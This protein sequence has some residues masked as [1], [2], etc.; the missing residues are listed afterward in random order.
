MCG[1]FFDSAAGT[2]VRRARGA[3][4]DG[5]DSRAFD[6]IRIDV[7]RRMTF[8]GKIFSHDQIR[9]RPSTLARNIK[10]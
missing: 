4:S 8:C 7:K 1:K 10:L 3:E 5:V 2:V 6:R 9:H